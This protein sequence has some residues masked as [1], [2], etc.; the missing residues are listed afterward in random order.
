MR[1][2]QDALETHKRL[3][4]TVFFSL[5]DCSFNI[6]QCQYR[7]LLDSLLILKIKIDCDRSLTKTLHNG[8]SPQFSYLRRYDTIKTCL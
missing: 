3:F 6:S 7:H 2:F 1:N 5:Q 4:I 8:L